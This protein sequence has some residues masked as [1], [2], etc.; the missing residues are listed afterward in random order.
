[1][2]QDPRIQAR[3]IGDQDWLYREQQKR[4]AWLW[5]NALRRHNLVGFVGEVLKGVVRTKL[6][7]GNGEYEKWIEEGKRKTKARMEERE[8]KGGGVAQEG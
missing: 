5:E 8:K 3:Q 1:M 7:G 4:N 2:V 6:E